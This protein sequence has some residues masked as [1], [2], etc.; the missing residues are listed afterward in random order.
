MAIAFTVM[1]PCGVLGPYSAAL[2][3]PARYSAL[4][5]WARARA[6]GQ[7]YAI[8]ALNRDD[9]LQPFTPLANCGG[10]LSP[11]GWKA[12]VVP[13][14]VLAPKGGPIAGFVLHDALGRPQPVLYLDD[15]SRDAR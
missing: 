5:L 9:E 7:S 11:D 10:D 6:A 12:Y 2:V 4:R 15:I 8:A 3:D 1:K 13:L 14:A